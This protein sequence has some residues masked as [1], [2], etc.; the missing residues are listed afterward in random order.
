MGFAG[1]PKDSERADVLAIEHFCA[2][3]SI[4]AL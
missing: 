3:P 4:F 2:S 1:F